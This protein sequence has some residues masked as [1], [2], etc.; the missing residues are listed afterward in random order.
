MAK[1]KHTSAQ[2]EL[3]LDLERTLSASRKPLPFLSEFTFQFF[4]LQVFNKRFPCD[5]HMT[6]SQNIHRENKCNLMKTTPLVFT[7][8]FENLPV[9]T[10]ASLALHCVRKEKVSAPLASSSLRPWT[11]SPSSRELC[12]YNYTTYLSSL[13]S[14]VHPSLQDPPTH[15]LTSLIFQSKTKPNSSF[16]PTFSLS[17]CFDILSLTA[18]LLKT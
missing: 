14:P 17:Y 16:E 7:T 2:T 5:I 12:S 15:I 10:P 8:R 13:E 6:I 3:Y 4:S 11:L 18:K 9:S 1:E